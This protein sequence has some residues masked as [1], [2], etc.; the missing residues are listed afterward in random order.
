VESRHVSS[1]DS[2]RATS[3]LHSV[4]GSTVGIA[5]QSCGAVDDDGIAGVRAALLQSIAYGASCSRFVAPTACL[6]QQH[7]DAALHAPMDTP[8]D[9]RGKGKHIEQQQ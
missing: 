3:A 9:N 1:I 4:F 7:C 8:C 2:R 6:L 5:H